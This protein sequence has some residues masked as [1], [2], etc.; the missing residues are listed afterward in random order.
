ML[1]EAEIPTSWLVQYIKFGGW[2]TLLF[3]VM[4]IK[5]IFFLFLRV[6]SWKTYGIY[7]HS[8]RKYKFV[9]KKNRKQ[10]LSA[11]TQ[12]AHRRNACPPRF[13]FIQYV[14]T[15]FCPGTAWLPEPLSFSVAWRSSVSF[16][17]TFDFFMIY[18]SC[19]DDRRGI[20]SENVWRQKTRYE[21]WPIWLRFDFRHLTFTFAPFTMKTIVE[22]PSYLHIDPPACIPIRIRSTKLLLRF[23]V[24]ISSGWYI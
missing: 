17:S 16:R 9:I 23:V 2:E 11:R 6:I 24:S 22:S 12:V 18:I 8:V 3:I 4:K 1:F 14:Y 20:T 5:F 19:T 15:M 7:S 10:V 13:I 21:I